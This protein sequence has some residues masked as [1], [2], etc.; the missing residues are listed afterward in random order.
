MNSSLPISVVLV[1]RDGAKTLARCLTSVQPLT[2]DIVVILDPRTVDATAAVCRQFKA[3]V[4][5]RRFDDFSGQ[6]NYALSQAKNSWVLSLDADEWLSPGLQQE[7]LHLTLL[8]DVTA[9]AIPRKNIIFG[10][11]IN[12]TNW[13]PNGLVR[14]FDKTRSSWQ[15]QVHEQLVTRG[16]TAGLISPLMHENYRTVEEFLTRQDAYSTLAAQEKLQSGVRFSLF[17]ALFQPLG[18]FFRRYIW[19]AG[20]LDGWHGLFLSYLM[21]QYHFSV[22]VKLWQKSHSPSV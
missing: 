18:E 3:R 9:Y 22:W 16:Q 21:A 13:D 14:F 12:H 17:S 2:S 10:R 19:H 4:Y 1:V 11:I 6:K 20:F 8:P 7:L 5:T 15:G